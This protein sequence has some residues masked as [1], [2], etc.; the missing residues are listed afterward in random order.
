MSNQTT[1]KGFTL[2]E[3]LI[4][5]IVLAMGLLGFAAL[6]AVTLR[7]SQSAYYRSIATNVAYDIADRIRA[8]KGGAAQYL[9]APASQPTCLTTA[10]CT[11]AQMAQNDLQ[12]WYDS[13]DA[14]LPMGDGDINA[15]ANIYTV[16]VTWDDDHSGLI[17]EVDPEFKM[18]FRP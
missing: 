11:P 6:N 17:N 2:I 7:N 13:L 15:A 5:V 3:V 9:G 10:G 14:L 1:N 12:N 8:N 18:S 16:T 4:A